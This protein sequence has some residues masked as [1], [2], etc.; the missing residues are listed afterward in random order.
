MDTLSAIV[1]FFQDGGWIMYPIVFVLAVGVS[2]AVERWIYLTRTSATNQRL[3]NSI[4]PLLK[5][6]NL[7]QVAAVTRDSK[8]AIGTILSYGLDRVRSA[9]RREDIEQ[10]MEESLMEIVPRLERRTHYLATFANIATLLG[11]LGTVMGLIEAFTA[12][13]AANPTEKA[14]MLSSSISVAMNAT[15]FGLVVAIPLLLIHSVLTSKTTRIVDS[16]EMAAVKFLNS[17]SERAPGAAAQ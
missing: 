14:S 16:L 2:I 11:L 7:P 4:V 6:G 10:A 9:R 8:T 13:A 3:W 1:R 5:A 17:L 15:A 12:V